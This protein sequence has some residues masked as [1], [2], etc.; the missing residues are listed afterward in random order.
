[1]TGERGGAVKDFDLA[2]Y[3]KRCVYDAELQQTI[4]E[5][6]VPNIPVQIE[7]IEAAYRAG[8]ADQLKREAH[9]LK[10]TSGTLSALRL[11]ESAE[12]LEIA[13][14]ESRNAGVTEEMGSLIEEA[15][16]AYTGFLNAVREAGLYSAVEEP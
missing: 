1:V 8:N 14:D 11:Q 6:S 5:G 16:R 7:K 9:G 12:R 3:E 4:M 2:A 10:G 13:A 15:K